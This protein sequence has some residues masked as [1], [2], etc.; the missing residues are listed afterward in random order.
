MQTLM[1]TLN[2]RQTTQVLLTREISENAT[3]VVYLFTKN[4]QLCYFTMSPVRPFSSIS[5]LVLPQC[6][7]FNV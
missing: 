2:T 5:A 1:Q 6:V 7:R 4:V 3:S